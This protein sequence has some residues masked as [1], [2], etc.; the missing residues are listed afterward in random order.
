MAG[1]GEFA[2]AAQRPTG[3]AEPEPERDRG[4]A[5]NHCGMRSVEPIPDREAQRLLVSGSETAPGGGQVKPAGT[6]QLRV[7]P[8]PR[9][10]DLRHDDR[11]GDPDGQCLP[12]PV[13]ALTVQ[14]GPLGDSEQPRPRIPGIRRQIVEATPCHQEDV[15]SD[16]L[17]VRGV[18]AALHESE[19]VRI[20]RLVHRPEPHLAI[21]P[22]SR[23]TGA[24]IRG[25]HTCP[26]VLLIPL[27]VR[28]RC[29]RV[30]RPP[31][32][33]HSGLFGARVGSACDNS[34]GCHTQIV[35]APNQLV[36]R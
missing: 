7:G 26:P 4:D 12:T 14:Q 23:A 2:V 22:R 3:P 29:K 5:E 16:V 19:E 35:R 30:A 24:H 8:L 9:F 17:G 15:G 28:H 32:F 6:V 20:R 21:W 34:D 25:A 31:N 1:Q 18:N 10:P 36:T 11:I 33:S 27:H 13:A